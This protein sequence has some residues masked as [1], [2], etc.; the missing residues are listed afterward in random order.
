MEEMSM[1]KRIAA[2]RKQKGLTQEQLAERVSVSPQ[3]V[4]KWENDI[5]C[6]DISILARLAEVLGVS[7]DELLG[8][9]PIEP[10]VVV[11][12][13]KG[14]RKSED[15][16]KLEFDGG[17]RGGVFFA[18]MV[19]LVG[20]AFLLS[21][22]NVFPLGENFNFWDI[23]WPALM[24]GCGVSWFLNRHSL[25]PLGVAVSG[26][27]FLL[28][29]LGAIGFELTWGLLWPVLLVLLG[30]DILIDKL[31]R[32]KSRHG[33]RFNG[34]D[35]KGTCEY[36]EDDG[37]VHLDIS[38]CE[39]TRT[40]TSKALSGADVDVSFGAGKLYLTGVESVTPSA[41][42][43]VDVSFGSYEIFLPRSI[44]AYVDVDKAFGSISTHGAPRDDAPYTLKID[45]DASFGS[46]DIRYI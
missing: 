33:V 15:G 17:K 3:A 31:W 12:D 26:L 27:L 39:D 13:G 11:L 36:S 24:L 8:V 42:L 38:F 43:D 23:V 30:L 21:K 18:V 37:Y 34:K 1:G 19:I 4:S 6:P 29:N 22:L 45:G 14:E 25:L 20:V 5:S 10:H 7:T 9:K 46:I 16:F 41:K 44:R 35:H 2:L 40:I 28:F 32:K